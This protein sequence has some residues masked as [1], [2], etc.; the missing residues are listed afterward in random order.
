MP[1]QVS[2]REVTPVGDG[3]HTSG[4]LTRQDPGANPTTNTPGARIGPALTGSYAASMD[5]SMTLHPLQSRSG[6]PNPL[7]GIPILIAML[8]VSRSTGWFE[9]GRAKLLLGGGD[10]RGREDV[11]KWPLVGSLVHQDDLVRANA[12][13]GTTL[14]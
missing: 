8:Y 4:A 1:T 3:T 13:T 10:A 7:L 6:T 5:T 9:R 12:W 11:P 2:R 14:T